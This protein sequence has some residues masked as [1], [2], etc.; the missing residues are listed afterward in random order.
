MHSVLHIMDYA[1]PYKGNFIPSIFN[2]IE[3]LN[4]SANMLVYLF[5]FSTIKIDWVEELERQGETIYYIDR[6]FFS[7][8][9][10]LSNIKLLRDIII[11]E[12]VNIIHTHFVA[13]NYTLALMKVFIISRIKIIGNFMNEYLPPL[14]IYN[15]LKVFITKFT[16]DKII[17]SS[18]AVKLSVLNT[19]INET[20]IATIYNTLDIKYLQTFDIINLKDNDSQKIILMFGWTFRRKGVDIAIRVIK[21]LIEE[22]QN[23]R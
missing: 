22:R 23:L 17:A 1:A 9:I 3:H 11:R 19:G 2:L 6:S 10:K 4:N 18:V 15:K 13:Y 8:N 7:K 16:Y 12:N 5:P 20:E 21:G 14:Y